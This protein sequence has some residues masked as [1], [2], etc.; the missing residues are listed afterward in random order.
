VRI[1]APPK[2]PWVHCG[3]SITACLSV[4]TCGVL[5]S[6]RCSTRG[7]A[8]PADRSLSPRP[9][10]VLCC[11]GATVSCNNCEPPLSVSVCTAT[12]WPTCPRDCALV[13]GARGGTWH[14]RQLTIIHS[15]STCPPLSSP[16]P[17]CGG[18]VTETVCQA[19]CHPFAPLHRPHLRLRYSVRPIWLALSYFLRS[20]SQSHY[21]P[22]RLTLS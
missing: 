16:S 19:P 9:F 15:S 11:A 21:R 10:P 5:L 4:H 18:N 6:V 22:A 14:I 8:G 7:C 2:R 13:C 3:I 20:A 1:H 17:G 12:I